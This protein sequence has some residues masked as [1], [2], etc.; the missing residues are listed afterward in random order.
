MPLREHPVWIRVEDVTTEHLIVYE[1]AIFEVEEIQEKMKG[2]IFR[3][4]AEGAPR[5]KDDDDLPALFFAY[6]D[7]V[8]IQSTNF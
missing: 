6:G 2:R 1:G 7:M 8:Q 5:P 4:R 3:V